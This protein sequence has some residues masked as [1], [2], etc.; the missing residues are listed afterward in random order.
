[1]GAFGVYI[2]KGER[3]VGEFEWWRMLKGGPFQKPWS[4]QRTS[5]I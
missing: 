1:M 4:E 5:G 3:P 2:V